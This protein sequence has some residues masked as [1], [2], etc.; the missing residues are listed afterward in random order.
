M[1]KQNKFRPGPGGERRG[2]KG[3]LV[4]PLRSVISLVLETSH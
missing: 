3:E 4:F 1:D 2:G